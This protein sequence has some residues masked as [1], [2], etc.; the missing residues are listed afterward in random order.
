MN[1]N[2]K[3]Y[4]Q[5]NQHKFQFFDIPNDPRVPRDSFQYPIEINSVVC[6]IVTSLVSP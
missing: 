5:E 2:I 1:V 6:I 4:F 3:N